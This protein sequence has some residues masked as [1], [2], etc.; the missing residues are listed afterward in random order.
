VKC[1]VSFGTDSISGQAFSH[2]L[3]EVTQMLKVLPCPQVS[4]GF[5]PITYNPWTDEDEPFIELEPADLFHQSIGSNSGPISIA[6]TLKELPNL[7][8]D[9][10]EILRIV[11]KITVF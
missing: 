5:V 4:P 1:A 7:K 3:K 6:D 2:I 9:L 11:N 8:I 10:W